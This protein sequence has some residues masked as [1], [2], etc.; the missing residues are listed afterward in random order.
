MDVIEPAKLDPPSVQMKIIDGAAFVNINPPRASSTYSEYCEKEIKNKVRCLA[1]ETKRVDLVFDVYRHDSLKSETRQTRGEG[2]RISVRK[3]TPVY[4]DF[5]RFMRNDTNKTELFNMISNEVVCIPT[6]ESTIVATV[7]D[8]VVS[9]IA[10]DT[11]NLGEC[12]H[13]EADTRLLLH[14]YDAFLNGFKKI[15]IITVD[16]DVVVI[17]LHHFT[18][19]NVEELW[20]EFGAGKSRRFI[21]IH[22][23]AKKLGEKL[24]NGLTFWHALTG[25]D[26]VSMF[27]GKGKRTSWK[28][29]TSF[30]EAIDRFSV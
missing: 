17:A 14:A 21:P 2:V 7:S 27:S 18:K 8:R 25:C 5:Q 11:T 9:N 12:N 30:P 29:Y 6:Q 20:I 16:T 26:T 23:Y 24:C 4:K 28:V 19:L 13:E 22:V 15:L 10:I 3:N 1:K